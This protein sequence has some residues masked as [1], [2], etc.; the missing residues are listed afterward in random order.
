MKLFALLSLLISLS[1]TSCGGGGSDAPVAEAEAETIAGLNIPSTV[2]AVSDN[3]SSSS[4]VAGMNINWSAVSAAFNSPDTDYST[5]AVESWM[6][7]PSAEVMNLVNMILCVMEGTGSEKVP[8]GN[9]RALVDSGKCDAIESG[10]SPAGAPSAF[11]KAVV[12]STRADNS[13]PQFVTLWYDK[14]SSGE[15]REN[16]IAK[17]TIHKA[18]SLTNPYGEF[19]LDWDDKKVGTVLTGYLDISSVNSK[20]QIQL[21]VKYNG[22][23]GD[24]LGSVALHIEIDSATGTSGRGIVVPHYEIGVDNRNVNKL[25][26]T[27]DYVKSIKA[28][29]SST[30]CYDRNDIYSSVYRTK[31][32]DK[33]TGRRLDLKGGFSATY[34]KDGGSRDAYLGRWGLWTEDKDYQPAQIT[35]RDDDTAYGMTYTPGKLEKRTKGMHTLADGDEF[36]KW[37][38]NSS[39]D[40]S[41]TIFSWNAINNRFEKS[42]GSEMKL[43]DR[44]IVAG[45]WMGSL[46]YDSYGVYMGEVGGEYKFNYYTNEDITPTNSDLSS[47]DILFTCYGTCPTG[48]VS[49]SDFDNQGS[50][51]NNGQDP[52]PDYTETGRDY[53]FDKETMTLAYNG[54]PIKIASAVSNN[55][56]YLGMYLVSR[57]VSFNDRWEQ[58]TSYRWSLS[59][60]TKGEFTKDS[61]G[62]WYAFDKPVKFSYTHK[63]SNDRNSKSKYNNKKLYLE[64]NGS[65]IEGFS[66]TKDSEG[67]WIKD[68]NL[69]DGIELYTDDDDKKYVNKAVG[70]DKK[71]KK[72]SSGDAGFDAC[73]SL[74]AS[75]VDLD[76]PGESGLVEITETWDEQNSLPGLSDDIS[77]IHGVI[78]RGL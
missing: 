11:A 40:C 68:I 33:D 1:L 67:R 10:S 5:D 66:W 14:E 23:S 46:Q 64:Y 2:S 30:S 19:R 31:L 27:K 21:F 12:S 39:G 51:I 62:N 49:Q 3:S 59:S 72:L 28:S 37:T 69:N 58:D 22:G 18:S 13:S 61:S 45:T 60:W 4:S 70:I 35:K 43:W 55:N 41:Q 75:G 78:Q 63:T 47:G 8:I 34:I 17:L 36:R 25:T 76:I 48:D 6:D 38:C 26:Y 52:D 29:D 16:I 44:S 71:M 57:G 9:Y 73:N 32:Y 24:A 50:H 65:F 53:V 56:N 54:T 15:R 77:V 42:D 20:P 74:D 7:N